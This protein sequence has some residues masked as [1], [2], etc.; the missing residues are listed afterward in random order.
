MTDKERDDAIKDLKDGLSD[1][2]GTLVSINE[3]LKTVFNEL[4]DI[5]NTLH[6]NGRQGLVERVTTL[7]VADNTKDST[8]GKIVEWGAI[9]LAAGLS[10]F[11]TFFRHGGTQ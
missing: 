8:I 4:R 9:I 11:N 10:L 5:K 7:E 6:G 2:N 3:Q 1:V